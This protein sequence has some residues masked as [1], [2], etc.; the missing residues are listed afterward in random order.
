VGQPRTADGDPAD[1]RAAALL[2]TGLA[3]LTAGAWLIIF[4]YLAG[5]PHLLHP[6]TGAAFFAGE[7]RR[8]ALG[9]GG[10]AAA[11]ATALALPVAALV[12]CL[13]LPIFYA[14]TSAGRAPR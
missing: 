6:H 1:Q 5:H 3:G 2:Y 11:A 13:A 7:R 4:S 8:A 10:Y 12:L 14:V 9:I